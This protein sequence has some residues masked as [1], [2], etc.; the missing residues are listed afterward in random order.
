MS[1]PLPEFLLN[2]VSPRSLRFTA[3]VEAKASL[4]SRLDSYQPLSP[5]DDT[6]SF[7]RTFFKYL[8]LEGQIHLVED[9]S[10]CSHSDQLAELATGID[11]ELL[12]P[13]LIM[14]GAQEDPEST[15]EHRIAQ[16]CL[17]RDG[18]LCIL[19]KTPARRPGISL[20]SANLQFAYIIPRPMGVSRDDDG[21]K[22][23]MSAL[24]FRLF[25]YF[26]AL[27][28]DL[29]MS[30]ELVNQEINVM[31]LNPAFKGPF[32]TFCLTLE[33][34]SVPDQYHIKT[35]PRT[36][37]L[38]DALLPQNRFLTL[39]QHDE[40]VPLPCAALLSFHA[41]IANILHESGRDVRTIELLRAA[42]KFRIMAEDGSSNIGE[43]LPVYILLLMASGGRNKR[44]PNILLEDGD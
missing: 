24:W 19:T 14:G 26:P 35:F 32:E 33:A 7:L 28:V 40:R 1:L 36:T 4:D 43:M 5:E 15:M 16:S 41:A 11:V 27:H 31:V 12:R 6:T 2:P 39:A 30:P 42:R 34:T 23:I 13:L 22:R 8:P 18:R 10:Q 21:D 37:A 38:Y 17:R 25:R 9:V 20:R 44:P 29:G 3:Y